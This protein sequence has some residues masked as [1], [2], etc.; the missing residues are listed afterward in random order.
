[1]KIKN[2][3]WGVHGKMKKR[4]FKK[5][6]MVFNCGQVRKEK[7]KENEAKHCT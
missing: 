2:G 6:K 5:K 1:M 4:S 3:L 7:T